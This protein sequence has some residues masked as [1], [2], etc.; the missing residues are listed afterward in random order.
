MREYCSRGVL[1][2]VKLARA[3]VSMCVG[4]AILPCVSA[5]FQ[6]THNGYRGEL[7]SVQELL[8]GGLAVAQEPSEP[9]R[10]NGLGHGRTRDA[11]EN[12]TPH[13]RSTCD[14]REMICGSGASLFLDQDWF[15][16]E[17]FGSHTDRNYTMGLAFA[18]S[19]PAVHTQSH[20][21]PL[22]GM[23]VLADRVITLIPRTFGAQSQGP[24]RQLRE[25]RGR[26]TSYS[27]MLHGTAFTPDSIEDPNPILDDRP[28]A[29]LLGWTVAR[30]TIA[31][32]ENRAWTSELTIGTI[33]GRLG[34][35]VQKGIHYAINSNQ[36]EG[37]ANQLH[38][39]HSPVF[40]V[41]TGR[42]ALGYDR[43]LRPLTWAQLRGRPRGIAPLACSERV[44]SAC[45]IEVTVNG[46]GEAG[47]YT[48][49]NAGVRTRFG[50]FTTPFWAQRMN[51]L[52]VG[53]RASGGTVTPIEGFLFA[54]GRARYIAYNA[55]LSGYGA[56]AGPVRFS[57]NQVRHDMLEWELGLALLWRYRPTRSVQVAWVADAGRTPEFR[58]PRARTHHWGGVYV[59]FARD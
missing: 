36:P 11:A 1:T 3:A 27:E 37:W 21:A 41:L 55:L 28:Y 46:G 59:T 23:E 49:A 58:G 25:G 6:P 33:G 18:R 22:R 35:E 47:Y 39:T 52:G 56:G 34:R 45:A 38:D 16:H 19:G 53:S 30:T 26:R 51:P 7:S 43:V 15:H 42:Y 24:F 48:G 9:L 32:Q 14:P 5:G 13:R 12:T 29:F 20:D 31:Q 8:V 57:D 17:Y 2:S 44:S 50:V 40:G 4:L 54:G 10:P